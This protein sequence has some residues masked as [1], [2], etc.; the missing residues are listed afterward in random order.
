M[1]TAILLGFLF[2]LFL[3]FTGKFFRGKLAIL[4]ALIPAGLFVYFASFIPQISSGEIISKTYQWVPAFGVDLSF[5]L[6]GLSLL[7]SLMI[8]GIGFLVFAYTAS[9]L[10]GHKYLDRFYGYLSLFMA[11]MLGLVLSDNLISLFVFW[12]LTSISSFFLIGFNNTNPASRK[13][14]LTALG[15]TGFGGFSLLAGALLLGSITGTYSISEMLSMKEAIAGSEYYI[16]AVVFIFVA[17]FTKS[18][19]FPFHFWLPGAMKAPTPVSTYLH[20]ATMVKAGIYLLMRFTPVLGDQEFW[21]TTL[22]IVG[23]IT[24]VYSAIHT[25]FRTDLKGVLAYS[26]I[27]ALGILVF[28]IGLGSKD[29]F[30]AASVFIIVHAL[31]KATLFLVTGIIDHQT[32]TRDVTKLAGLRKIMMPVAIAGILAAI[33]SAGIPPT[34]GFLGKELTYEASMHAET[35]TIVIVIAIVLT[36]ILLLWAGFVAG[37]KP[38]TGKL[39]EPYKDVK[40]PDF[41]MWG[42][43]IILA[44]LGLL[45]GIFPMIIE[46]AL[47][48]PVVSALGAD[49]SEY[50][51]ALWHGFN[52]VLLLSAITIVVGILLYFFVKPSAN[53]ENRIG[54]LEFISPKSILEKGT[55]YFNVFSAFWT[56]VFQNGYLRNYVTTIVLFLVVLVS[57]IMFGSSRVVID[58][59]QLSQVTAYELVVALILIAGVFYTVFTKSRLA[60]VAAMGVVGLAICLIFVFYSAP[61]LAMTQFSIDTLTVILFVLV[62]YR[63]PKYLTLSDYKMR[64]RDGVLSAALGTVVCLLALQVLA[65]PTNSELGDFY[66]KNAYIMAHGKNV[67]NVILVDFRGIDTFMEISVLAIAAIGVFGLLKLRLKSTDRSQ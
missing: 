34:I 11:A 14:A 63:L 66:A 43:A 53:L 31:Y 35:L 61:D 4:S 1:L 49:A 10:R 21:N 9:Y 30:M 18:A 40:A 39:P 26:T 44:V 23:G 8:T 36:K 27:S 67:V 7:F 59:T 38:F 58:H 52:T 64:V 33:S 42:P 16:L 51:L 22:I 55:H 37:I 54:K 13:S 17:A 28:L 41:L 29:A 20:S 48:K 60:A 45:F 62:L 19:Q 56:N 32:G 24:M 5:K 15:I 25:L 3:V 50:H 12:E 65:E 47:V 6:D 2:A 46:S 57:Y